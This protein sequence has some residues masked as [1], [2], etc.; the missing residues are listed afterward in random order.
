[1]KGGAVALFSYLLEVS[2]F[3]VNK[4]LFGRVYNMHMLA[5]M[6]KALIYFMCVYIHM[7]SL[8]VVSSNGL[9]I[10]FDFCKLFQRS[11][12]C[13]SSK[14][15]QKKKEVKGQSSCT[16]HVCKKHNPSLKC[17]PLGG[18]FPE[19]LMQSGLLLMTMS[20]ISQSTKTHS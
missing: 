12:V 17:S 19:G 3:L 10:I 20:G 16:S 6:T 8:A 1:M 14:P 9:T 18:S 4:V 15:E 11:L 5:Y 13:T 7:A 2:S